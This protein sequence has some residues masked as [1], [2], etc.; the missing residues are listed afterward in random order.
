M[1]TM[2]NRDY[3][4]SLL[5]I[6]NEF[7]NHGYIVELDDFSDNE[8]K[9]IATIDNGDSMKEFMDILNSNCTKIF[10]IKAGVPTNDARVK[11]LI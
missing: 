7:K 1:L 2:H 10:Y 6:S 11:E 9:L 3:K 8:G 4:Q 5:D